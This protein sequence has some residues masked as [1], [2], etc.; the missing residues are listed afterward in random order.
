M[1]GPDNVRCFESSYEVS[2]SAAQNDAYSAVKSAFQEHLP[3]LLN[4]ITGSGKTEIYVKL[5][6]E[7]M[8]QGKNVLYMIPEIAVS[9]QLEERLRRIFGAY[10][11]T[12]HSKVTAAKRE[13]VASEIRSGN[14]IVLGTRSSIFL[15][16]HDL[17]LII[18]D[19][20]H[21]TSYKQ[22]APAPRYN[23]RD[24]ALMLARIYGAEIILGTATPSLE[25]LYIAESGG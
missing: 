2:L 13:D 9:R 25:S 3:V 24:T 12:F 11:F 10:L 14:Y 16:H 17:E 23:G 19:E 1:S 21:D 22:D 15:P 20:E 8:R 18:V 4:G 7:T 5:A 6:L